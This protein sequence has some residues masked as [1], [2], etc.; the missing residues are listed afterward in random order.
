VSF[1]LRDE[2]IPDACPLT[3]QEKTLK[4]ELEAV[5][6]SGLDEFLRV[7]NA[8]AMLRNKRLFRTEFATFEEY[9]RIKFCLARS[10]ADQLIRCAQTAQVLLEAGVELPANTTSTLMKPIATLPGEELQVA[11]WEFAQSLAPGR[12]V[13]QP[14]VSR[15]VRVVRNALEGRDQDSGDTDQAGVSRCRN[16]RRSKTSPERE[17]PFIRP[18]E[19]LAAWPGFNVEIIVSNVAP[20]S[21]TT[22][23][24]ACGILSD[25]CQRVQ[26]RLASQYPELAGPSLRDNQA[27][28]PDPAQGDS[29]GSA[30]L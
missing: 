2:P 19:R 26:E 13:T 28:E 7:G 11:C 27:A 18:V 4:A 29:R 3:R 16:R 17:T 1:S 21:A 8:L 12:G 23:Y 25:R 10:S 20:P 9:V 22:V 24:R 6:R 30:C 15:L 5:V 14:L